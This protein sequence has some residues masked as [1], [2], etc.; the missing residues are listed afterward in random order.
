MLDDIRD[1]DARPT[2]AE[3]QWMAVDAVEI[4]VKSLA[5]AAIAL[6]VGVTASILL[7]SSVTPGAETVAGAR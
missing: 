2:L 3:R 7:D 6:T 1:H 4:I 5:L